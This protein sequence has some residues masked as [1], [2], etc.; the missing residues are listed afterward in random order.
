MFRVDNAIIP[1][2]K[3]TKTAKKVL[4][5]CQATTTRTISLGYPGVLQGNQSQPTVSEFTVTAFLDRFRRI[6]LSH[7]WLHVLSVETT[8]PLT[9]DWARAVVAVCIE[10]YRCDVSQSFAV[11]LREGWTWRRWTY[12]CCSI[13]FRCKRKLL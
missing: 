1:S 2:A 5:H 3:R 8:H 13:W 11:P 7:F 10:Y 4:Q 9:L 12:A 6:Y